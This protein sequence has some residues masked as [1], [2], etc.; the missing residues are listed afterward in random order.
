MPKLTAYGT[1]FR[2]WEALLGAVERNASLLPAADSLKSALESVLA[3]TREMKVQ[4]EDL[5]GKRQATT[6]ALQQLV[7][8]GGR[9]RGSCAPTW[10]PPWAH[11]P[12]C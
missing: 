10:S 12:S 11:G 1:I 6:Q 8:S 2:D 9:P 7:D 4:Q 3:K 5:E